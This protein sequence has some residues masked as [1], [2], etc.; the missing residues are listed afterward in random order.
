MFGSDYMKIYNTL[1]KGIEEF[2]PNNGYKSKW[3]I[4]TGIIVI[5]LGL[6]LLFYQNCMELIKIEYTK[7]HLICSQ[8][9]LL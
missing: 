4:M 8:L 9:F 3:I 6:F 7:C 1:T 2:V 5:P